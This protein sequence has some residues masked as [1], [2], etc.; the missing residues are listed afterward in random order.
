[1]NRWVHSVF[2]LSLAGLVVLLAT[3]GPAL[4]GVLGRHDE[5]EESRDA[6][7]GGCARRQH[8]QGGLADAHRQRSHS[9]TTYSNAAQESIAKTAS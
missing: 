2:G 8:G 7:E 1:M 3:H 9:V 4:I 6:D 5:D